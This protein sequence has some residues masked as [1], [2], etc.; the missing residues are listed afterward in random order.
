MINQWK[1][2]STVCIFDADCGIC[3][4]SVRLA[5]R[6]HAR[7]E[8]IPSQIYDFSDAPAGLTPERTQ[9]EVVC[10]TPAGDVFGGAAA[11]AQILRMSRI[12]PLGVILD[13]RVVLPVARIVYSWVA[14]NRGRLPQACGVNATSKSRKEY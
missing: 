12:A 13:S 7:V 2:G 9:T 11:V 14:R 3:Q 6:L 8:F 1:S 5:R 10:V 4:S